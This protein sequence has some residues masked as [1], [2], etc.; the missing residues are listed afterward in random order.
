MRGPDDAGRL[1][2]LLLCAFS[3]FIRPDTKPCAS[4]ERRCVLIVMVLKCSI[5]FLLFDFYD[6]VKSKILFTQNR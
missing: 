3:P 4:D 1:K 6:C 2:R 5:N